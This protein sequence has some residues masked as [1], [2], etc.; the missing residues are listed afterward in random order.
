MTQSTLGTVGPCVSGGW[1]LDFGCCSDWSGYSADLKA[2]ATNYATL[3]LWAAT[4]RRF[5][6]CNYTVRPCGRECQQGNW[7]GGWYWT[8]G[9]WLP[10]IFNGIWRNCWSGCSG[11]L[12]CTCQPQCQVYLPG[13]V[14][15]INSV[16]LDGATVDPSTYRV[17]NGIWLVRTRDSESETDPPC[18]PTHQDYDLNSGTD[19][20]IVSYAKGIVVPP[21]LLR[22]GGELAC[23]Y[24]KACLGQPCRLPARA[25]SIARQGVT[26][27]VVNIDTM[28]QQG[29]TGLPTVDQII[30]T[31]NPYG[32]K[33]KMRISSP[34]DTIERTVT[35]P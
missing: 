27:S 12:G 5:G 10:Y 31:L 7:N 23:E 8:E 21:A 35:W 26:V 16:T 17:D 11:I 28:L 13:P 2:A 24:A 14:N 30:A 19:T 22:A 6:L 18:W 29:F 33:G 32:L 9:T 3:V 15:S 34:D 4:G 1:D 25:T 20:F